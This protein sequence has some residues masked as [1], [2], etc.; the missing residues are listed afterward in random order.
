MQ[1]LSRPTKKPRPSISDYSDILVPTFMELKKIFNAEGIPE[2]YLI[3]V[4]SLLEN[5]QSAHREADLSRDKA[6]I[7]DIPHYGTDLWQ[8]DNVKPFIEVTSDVN[9]L[10]HDEEFLIAIENS[11]HNSDD[12]FPPYNGEMLARDLRGYRLQI[13]DLVEK[14]KCGSETR[15]YGRYA[16]DFKKSPFHYDALKL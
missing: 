6:L 16:I 4:D 11:T 13:V 15:K 8:D 14:E 7:N 2:G 12:D 5:V 1:T 10:L 9:R 3:H